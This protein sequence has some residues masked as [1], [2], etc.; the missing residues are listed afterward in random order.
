MEKSIFGALETLS[1]SDMYPFHMPGHK[2]NMG[3]HP[4]SRAYEMDIT[5]IEGFDNL[6]EPGGLIL[7]SMNRAKRLYGTK[8]TFFLVNGS[9][10]GI[11][12][13]IHSCVARGG[14]ILI[15]RNSHKSVYNAIALLGLKAAYLYP[16]EMGDWK[17]AAGLS[18]AEVRRVL[19]ANPDTQAILVTSPTYDGF[20]SPIREIADLA[21]EAGIPLIV[22]EAHGAHF[23]FS[24]KLPESALTGG[25]DL[26]IQSIHKTM[27]SF[28]QTALL[29]L[30]GNLVQLKVVKRYLSIFQSSSPSYLLM[31]GIDHCV[32]LTEERGEGFWDDILA[33]ADDFYHRM[34]KLKHMQVW[35]GNRGNKDLLFR[36]GISSS[37]EIKDPL[38]LIIRPVAA[39]KAGKPYTGVELYQELLKTYYLQMEM[40]TPTY[41]LGILTCMDR[42]EGLRRREKALF[43]ID[44]QLAPLEAAEKRE[45]RRQ[46][47]RYPVIKETIEAA[48]SK[49]AELILPQLAEGRESADYINLYPPGIPLIVPGEVISRD[50]VDRLLVY[51][52]Q[53]LPL[54]GLAEGRIAV[55]QDKAKGKS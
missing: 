8:E 29:H 49:E 6:H 51:S 43:E 13:A 27:P 12:T 31:G 18:T 42:A 44:S 41:V 30:Q 33:A 15:S 40:M 5:E 22:D 54:Q 16:E 19:A 28:T 4:L 36:Y 38:K 10:A 25:A 23:P 39:G 11:L 1:E 21:H 24:D 45:E 9:T 35:C 46:D 55:V 26:V 32:R 37:C 52:K 17:L 7:E 14:K 48:L 2:R 3:K 50:L 20:V 53:D 47:S 34:R